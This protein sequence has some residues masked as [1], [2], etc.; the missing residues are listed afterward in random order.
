MKQETN[1]DCQ[2][3]EE[4]ARGRIGSP[5]P[6]GRKKKLSLGL[7][8]GLPITDAAEQLSDNGF[9]EEKWKGESSR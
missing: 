6:N 8:G 2:T 3:Q 1:R 4:S 9:E 7:S 5:S